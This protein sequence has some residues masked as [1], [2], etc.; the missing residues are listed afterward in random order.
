MAIAV[1][2]DRDNGRN[3]RLSRLVRDGLVRPRPAAP[4]LPLLTSRP[5]RVAPNA[6]AMDALIED[7]RDGR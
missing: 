5:P 4:R 1:N 7:R 6:S 3:G 2:G